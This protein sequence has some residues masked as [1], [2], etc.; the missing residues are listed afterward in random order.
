MDDDNDKL[1]TEEPIEDPPETASMNPIVEL[2][3][4]A[5]E[6]GL[7]SVDTSDPL[8][9]YRNVKKVLGYELWRDSQTFR[10]NKGPASYISDPDHAF[11]TLKHLF[12][13]IAYCYGEDREIGFKHVPA[14]WKDFCRVLEAEL[15]PSDNCLLNNAVLIILETGKR[16]SGVEKAWAQSERARL[17]DGFSEDPSLGSFDIT[18]P[19][20]P[21]ATGDPL[22]EE[23]ASTRARALLHLSMARM[24]LEYI[25]ESMELQPRYLNQGKRNGFLHILKRVTEYE[26][27][28]DGFDALDRLV[29]LIARCRWDSS[30]DTNRDEMIPQLAQAWKDFEAEYSNE[31]RKREI[32][33]LLKQD[34]DD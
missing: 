17:I 3:A 31:F 24:P 15:P 13:H 14:N 2:L 33:L 30:Q 22:S 23:Q 4:Y 11:W 19:S 8:Q 5:L 34:T 9:D 7:N 12:R 25:V 21:S 6:A 29:W 10:T 28:D 1:G 20:T 32:D 27:I 26:H 16:V 18:P